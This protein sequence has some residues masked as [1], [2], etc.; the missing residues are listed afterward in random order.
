MTKKKLVKKLVTMLV[1]VGGDSLDVN[2]FSLYKLCAG[3]YDYVAVCV[4]FG[5]GGEK[6]YEVRYNGDSLIWSP[7]DKIT[8]KK[9]LKQGNK[10]QAGIE[11]YFRYKYGSN[12]IEW[13]YRTK[14]LRPFGKQLIDRIVAY[15]V[16]ESNTGDNKKK[17]CEF[18]FEGN[19]LS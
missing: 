7:P 1:S 16:I 17:L 10:C 6:V 9:R 2:T 8:T 4:D 3:E 13:H 5:E 18:D 19:N 12:L 11:R 15:A 14:H